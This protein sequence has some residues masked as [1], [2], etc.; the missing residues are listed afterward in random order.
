M[1]NLDKIYGSKSPSGITEV[2]ELKNKLLTVAKY[3]PALLLANAAPVDAQ[4]IC[5]TGPV[6]VSGNFY[7]Y[8]ATSF[9]VDGD[10]VDDFYFYAGTTSAFGPRIGVVPLAASNYF[11]GSGSFGTAAPLA[12]GVPLGSTLSGTLTWDQVDGTLYYPGFGFG[13]FD[14]ASTPAYLGVQFGISGNT[15][16][17]WLEL[18]TAFT[19]GMP[20]LASVTINS[21]G[22]ESS[23]DTGLL[24]AEC[25]VVAAPIPTVGQ[26]GLISL[27]LMMLITGTLALMGKGKESVM[28]LIKE[29]ED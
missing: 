23:P 5:E 18:E 24:T 25:D 6:V 11:V 28:G 14:P 10:G 27:A 8:G 3:S 15:H 20:G 19:P 9:D 2:E 1:I 26:W 7:T 4:I 13:N 22:Y 29:D 21:W 12:A 17:G 16:Y